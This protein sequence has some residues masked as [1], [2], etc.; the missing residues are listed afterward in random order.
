MSDEAD[1][2]SREPQPAAHS[3]RREGDEYVCVD[4]GRRWGFE[5][6]PPFD[7]D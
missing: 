6:E 7:C 5:E 2:V 4:C 1:E 3:S